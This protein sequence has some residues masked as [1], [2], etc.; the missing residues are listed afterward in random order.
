MAMRVVAQASGSARS[1]PEALPPAP[2][3][4]E[5]LCLAIRHSYTSSETDASSRRRKNAAALCRALEESEKLARKKFKAAEKA[6]RLAAEQN[7][8]ARRMEG[9]LTPDSGEDIGRTTDD[10]DAPPVADVYMVEHSRDRKGKG[11]ARKW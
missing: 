4:D 10:D 7:R 9:F 5:A 3:D 1:A 8:A 11:P 6:A 2:D